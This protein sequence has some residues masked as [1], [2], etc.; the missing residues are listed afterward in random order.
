MLTLFVVIPLEFFRTKPSVAKFGAP[1]ELMAH[2]VAKYCQNTLQVRISAENM[3]MRGAEIF[4]S[5]I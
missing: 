3:G 4:S 1:E 2:A 5:K